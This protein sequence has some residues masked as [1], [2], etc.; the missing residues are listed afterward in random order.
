MTNDECQLQSEDPC[1]ARQAQEWIA[2]MQQQV[3]NRARLMQE[4]RIP[5]SLKPHLICEDQLPEPLQSEV[6]RQLELIQGNLA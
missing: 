2:E 1:L 5:V 3:D 4:F 6:K